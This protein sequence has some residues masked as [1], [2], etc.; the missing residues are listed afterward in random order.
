MEQRVK[1]AIR[2]KMKFIR[3]IVNDKKIGEVSIYTPCS[4]TKQLR[5]MDSVEYNRVVLG[6]AE[7]YSILRDLFLIASNETSNV[8]L[9]YIP[10]HSE[11]KER[12]QDWF[13]TATFHLDLVLANFQATRVKPKQIKSIL[14]ASRNKRKEIVDIEVPKAESET[15]WWELE[16]SLTAKSYSKYIIFSANRLGFLYLA[17]NAESFVSYENEESYMCEAHRHINSCDKRDEDIADF[18][19]FYQSD[20]MMK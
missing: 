13:K 16:N 19:Y 11:R 2:S 7:G 5:F 15:T 12:F 18:W 9:F 6:N 10:D 20:T 14:E 4:L 1:V 3:Q 8:S 17:E